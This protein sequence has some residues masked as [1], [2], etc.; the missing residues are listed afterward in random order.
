[1]PGC[2]GIAVSGDARAT[3]SAVDWFHRAGSLPAAAKGRILM[4]TFKK[5]AMWTG[6][7]VT[8][9]LGIVLLGG[10]KVQSGTLL[11]FTAFAMAVPVRRHRLPRW[12]RIVLVCA[13]YGLVMLNISTT[14]LPDPSMV[15][16]GE[17]ADWYTPT[18]IEFLDQVQYIFS[19]FLAQ[20]AP[21]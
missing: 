1:M 9:L 5:V 21:S 2:R 16:C 11:I 6:I 20:A 4:D 10:G 13:V 15:R 12:V 18:G 8:G 19:G 14:E 17:Y 3:G 7:V